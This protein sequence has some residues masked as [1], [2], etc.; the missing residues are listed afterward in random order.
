MFCSQILNVALCKEHQYG[1]CGFWVSLGS[2]LVVAT[3]TSIHNHCSRFTLKK[4]RCLVKFAMHSLIFHI[5]NFLSSN[6]DMNYPRRTYWFFLI[7]IC[8][9]MPE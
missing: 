6:L 5:F 2:N 8:A 7:V 4:E 1:V 9:I 3:G